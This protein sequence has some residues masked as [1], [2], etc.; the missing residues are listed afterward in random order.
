MSA[1][2]MPNIPWGEFFMGAPPGVP[3]SEVT[4][5]PGQAVPKD[6]TLVP[7]D[8][9]GFGLALSLDDLERLKV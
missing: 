4:P 9:P 1:I 8:G 6:G 2:A 7:N 3:L 5:F